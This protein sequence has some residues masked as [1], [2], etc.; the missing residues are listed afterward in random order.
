MQKTITL[1]PECS[2]FNIKKF[3][4]LCL[5][6][7]LIFTETRTYTAARSSVLEMQKEGS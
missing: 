4:I 3:K 1:T 5:R 7:V 6:S 2:M